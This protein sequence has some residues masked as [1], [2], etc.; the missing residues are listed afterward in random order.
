[1]PGPHQP[2]LASG[3][4]LSTS[5]GLHLYHE[6]KSPVV[7]YTAAQE[8]AFRADGYSDVYVPQEYPK[9]VHETVADKGAEAEAR[10]RG[11]I[12]SEAGASFPKVMSKTFLAPEGS[13]VIEDLPEPVIAPLTQS[14]VSPEGPAVVEA[15]RPSLR[16]PAAVPDTSHPV[17]SPVANVAHVGTDEVAD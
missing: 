15:V 10:K 8:S 13:E 3:G 5:D 11:F 16:T 7:A 6:E 17:V 4:N 1:M 12:P 2:G 9:V 14:Q